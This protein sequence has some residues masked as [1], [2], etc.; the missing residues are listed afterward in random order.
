[1]QKQIIQITDIAFFN[2]LLHSQKYVP[3]DKQNLKKRFIFTAH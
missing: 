2:F 3:S 1:M